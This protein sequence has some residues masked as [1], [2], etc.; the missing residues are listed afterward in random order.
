MTPQ[1]NE[2]VVYQ[3]NDI[4][5]IEVRFEDET[6]WLQQPRIA[7]L[8]ACSLENVR[9]HLK[10]IYANGELDKAATSK[11]SLEVRQE[12]TR[13]VTRRVVYYN[14]D[15]IISIGYR[16]NSI[17]GVRFRQWAFRVT[18]IARPQKSGQINPESGQIK[19]VRSYDIKSQDDAVLCAIQDCPGIKADG[20]FLQIRTSTR[21]VR[22]SLERL[23]G[24]SK[25]EYRGSKR[26]GGWYVRT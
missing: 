8:F 17:V 11:E 4:M 26:T 9:L 21:S 1:K 18:I 20:I 6:V 23:S 13:R 25:I 24:A 7:E 2:I 5:R 3:P 22:R 19:N 10:N 16:V 15:A 14:L 12:G